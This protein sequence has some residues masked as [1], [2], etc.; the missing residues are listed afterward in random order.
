MPIKTDE[1]RVA[2]HWQCSCWASPC[3]SRVDSPESLIHNV[4]AHYG[5]GA[6]ELSAA[7]HATV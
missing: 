6:A 4:Y 5:K 3:R 7:C 2:Q 1:D